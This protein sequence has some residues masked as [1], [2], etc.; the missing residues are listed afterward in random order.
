MG[1]VVTAGAVLR[2]TA[3]GR[4]GKPL[5]CLLSDNPAPSSTSA[6]EF[7]LQGGG[8]ANALD[9]QLPRALVLLRQR[10]SARGCAGRVAASPGWKSTYCQ[11]IEASEQK[12]MKAQRPL[13]LDAVRKGL[14][15]V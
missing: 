2:N 6:Q 1:A 10:Q 14:E 13:A 9:K 8:K 15:V 5:S 11:D 4:P 7:C 3:C 12:G